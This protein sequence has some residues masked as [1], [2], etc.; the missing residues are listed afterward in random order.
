[1][2]DPV[3]QRQSK[4]IANSHRLQI[5]DWLKDPRQ[6]FAPQIDGD[7]VEDGVCAARIEEKLGL[8]QPTTA[9]H[10]SVLIDAGLIMPKRIK[11]WTFYR[12]D[13]AAIAR[14]RNSLANH[15]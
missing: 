10:L 12:R 6:H 8:A 3:S 13:E 5:L 15:L 7:L 2:I 4:A 11:Q 14:F 1:M 9:R